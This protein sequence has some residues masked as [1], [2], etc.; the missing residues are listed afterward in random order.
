MKNKNK[1]NRLNEK[2]N[3]GKLT[4][5]H[6]LCQGGDYDIGRNRI[7]A[8]R[9]GRDRV[10]VES[11]DLAVGDAAQVTFTVYLVLFLS[12]MLPLCSERTFP[13]SPPRKKCLL[14]FC[15]DL[16]LHWRSQILVWVAA[17]KMVLSPRLNLIKFYYVAFYVG[18]RLEGVLS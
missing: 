6:S 13:S 2:N 10:R 7:R 14:R 16:R 18:W 9:G 17:G 5:Q 1:I 3:D 12:Y 11:V 15:F 4:V 8:D